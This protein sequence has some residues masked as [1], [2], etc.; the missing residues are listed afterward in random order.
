MTL[1][2][3]TGV[4]FYICGSLGT[5]SATFAFLHR[6]KQPDQPLRQAGA[7]SPIKALLQG[8]A[9]RAHHNRPVFWLTRH[10]WLRLLRI[11][12]PSGLSSLVYWNNVIDVK[13]FLAVF[14]VPRTLVRGPVLNGL[15]NR[16]FELESARLTKMH[17]ARIKNYK[18]TSH[19]PVRPKGSLARNRAVQQETRA[20][21]R[22]KH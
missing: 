18:H 3:L 22:T 13:P 17:H 9:D 1:Q 16:R 5:G 21:Q 8:A 6:T 2:A 19:C 14:V 11:L 15:S 20:L 10:S 4:G 7:D 12:A